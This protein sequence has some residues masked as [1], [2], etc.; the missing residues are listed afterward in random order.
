[1]ILTFPNPPTTTAL[2]KDGQAQL[3]VT[4]PMCHTPAGV[5]QSAI[6]KGADW[7]CGRCGQHW[8]ATRLLAVGAYA[9]WVA[10]RAAGKRL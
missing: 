9:A 8:D 3:G 10:D 4:C 5:M 7:R 6:D 2:A 1:M